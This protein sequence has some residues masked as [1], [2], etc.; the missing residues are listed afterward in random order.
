[1][2]FVPCATAAG[3]A[4]GLGL[5]E[6]LEADTTWLQPLVLEVLRLHPSSAAAA[7]KPRVVEHVVEIRGRRDEL[8]QGLEV[9]GAR[10]RTWRLADAPCAASGQVR[11][12]RSSC[13]EANMLRRALM[14]RVP[15]AAFH[16]CAIL[17]NTT[18]TPDEIVAHR[19][20]QLALLG[21]PSAE[22]EIR[23]STGVFARDLRC[24]GGGVAQDDQAL[25][26]AE[27]EGTL[28]LSAKSRLGTVA[29]DRHAKFAAVAAV[30]VFPHYC[31]PVV[32][33]AGLAALRAAGFDVKRRPGRKGWFLQPGVQRARAE[34]VLRQ[35]GEEPCFAEPEDFDVA[36]DSLGQLPAK[37]CLE[38]AVRGLLVEMEAFRACLLTGEATDLEPPRTAEEVRMA[39]A[40]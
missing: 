23:A 39:A 15:V 7:F 33:K 5:W 26:L 8:L 12:R 20:G 37:S 27:G 9:L 38:L 16:E 22:L 4:G 28:R 24:R 6:A 40:A 35:V 21:E 17:E 18:A 11:L 25:A 36:V 13:A 32:G 31:L 3:G 34:E 14:T 10:V 19:L 29:R 1:M 2:R 30:G